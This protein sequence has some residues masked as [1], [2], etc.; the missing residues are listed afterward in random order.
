MGAFLIGIGVWA[1]VQKDVASNILTLSSSILDPV[2]LLILAGCIIFV[3]GFF[4]C[5][6]A[7]RENTYLL[8]AYVICVGIILLLL[9][10]A[11]ILVF[12]CKEWLKNQIIASSLDNIIPK[13]RDDPD[14]QNLIDWVQG[15]WLYCCGLKD[16][17]DWKRNIYFNCS[18]PG[19]EACGVPFSC[20]LP[21]PSSS[22]VNIQCGYGAMQ[23]LDPSG[24]IYSKGCIEQ[25]DAWF[26]KYLIPIAGVTVAV[27]VIQILG[28]CFAWNLRGD[29]NAQKAKWKSHRNSSYSA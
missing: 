15:E 22:I 4:G 12:A 28:I 20:C 17:E 24:V 29:I 2:V 6:G 3:I 25:G 21:D 13:Y 14:L 27:A 9:I 23:L 1:A 19:V 11:A 10:V 7:L 18:S 26:N 16:Y 5:I 8:L